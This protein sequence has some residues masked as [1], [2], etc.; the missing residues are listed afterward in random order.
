MHLAWPSWVLKDHFS[1]AWSTPHVVEALQIAQ[2]LQIAV[3]KD[4]HLIYY[5]KLLPFLLSHEH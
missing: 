2:K 1:P 5:K 4:G 3:P